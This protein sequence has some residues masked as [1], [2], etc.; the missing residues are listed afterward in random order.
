MSKNEL[1]A[2]N[3]EIEKVAE[4]LDTSIEEGL[5]EEEA[6]TRLEKYGTNEIKETKK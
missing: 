5:S 2:H 1:K 6:Q 4:E 3:I